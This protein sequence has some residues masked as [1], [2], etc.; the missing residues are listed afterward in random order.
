MPAEYSNL[1]EALNEQP[2]IM[3]NCEGEIDILRNILRGVQG[4][5]DQRNMLLRIIKQNKSR[6]TI[7]HKLL[8]ALGYAEHYDNQTY[9]RY[10]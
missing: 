10:I 5:N 8:R 3:P 6:R 7:T 2:A 9:S 4:T 1:T